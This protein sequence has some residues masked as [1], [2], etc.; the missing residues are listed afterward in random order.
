[1]PFLSIVVSLHLITDEVVKRSLISF[2]RFTRFSSTGMWWK[3]GELVARTK[4]RVSLL[5]AA[6]IS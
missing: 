1:M 2:R 6:M 5:R 4:W 3:A